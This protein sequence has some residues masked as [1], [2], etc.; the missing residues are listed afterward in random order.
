MVLLVAGPN[1]IDR[2][3]VFC[4]AVAKHT[5]AKRSAPQ[6]LAAK[7]IDMTLFPAFQTCVNFGDHP[8]IWVT[9]HSLRMLS[10]HEWTLLLAGWRGAASGTH[11]NAVNASGPHPHAGFASSAKLSWQLVELAC[12]LENAPPVNVGR[13]IYHMD[14][15]VH[16]STLA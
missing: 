1:Q 4:K 6:P 5:Q 3:T 16:G 2:P 14:S 15:V 12:Y 11:L 9:R 7:E 8:E 13:N 10:A